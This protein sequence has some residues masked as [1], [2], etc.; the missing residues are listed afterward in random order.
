MDEVEQENKLFKKFME[1]D[2][3]STGCYLQPQR[4]Y[5]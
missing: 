1:C 3:N 5:H 2:V 4:S